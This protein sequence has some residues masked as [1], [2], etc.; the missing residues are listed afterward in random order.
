MSLTLASSLAGAL[1]LLG[2]CG[3]RSGESGNA[4]AAAAQNLLKRPAIQTQTYRNPC[5]WVS[6]EEVEQLLGKLTA[7]PRLGRDAE[8]R[9]PDQTGSSCV[10]ATAQAGLVGLQVDA[11]GGI[12]FEHAMGALGGL[13]AKEINDGK[14]GA[15][16]TTERSDGWDYV[17]GNPELAMYRVGH[18]AVQIG[19]EGYAVPQETQAKLA[20]LVRDRIQDLPV[21]L[22]G[23]DMTLGGPA[24]DPCALV[25]REE[26]ER[27][28]GK[29]VVEPFR[30]QESSPLANPKGVSCTFFTPGHHAL[31]I[32][33]TYSDG[34]TMF[35]MVNS[36]GGLTRGVLGGA[37]EGDLLDGPW[38]QAA[39]GGTGSLYFL[40]GEKMLEVIYQ[41]SSTDI[42]GAAQIAKAAM[43]R[44]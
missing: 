21:M 35:G 30:S 13:M 24:P 20:A 31:V 29:L 16:R 14:P 22:A 15:T 8:N 18:M 6:R 19:S 5:D 1:A 37:N 43:G 42:A 27:V 36:L 32:T 7:E 26:A 39:T 28:L 41:I 11:T 17:G 34:A 4:S 25:T 9:Q 33:P 3:Q 40:K 12:E 2:A 10:Y 44:L 23:T 38:D